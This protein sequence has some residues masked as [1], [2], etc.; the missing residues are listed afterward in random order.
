MKTIVFKADH[1][2]W[3]KNTP[4]IIDDTLADQF[5]QTKKATLYKAEAKPEKEAEAEKPE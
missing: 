3:P 5:I 1:E 2:F 4:V